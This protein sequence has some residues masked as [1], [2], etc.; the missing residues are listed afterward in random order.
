MPHCQ[1]S[2]CAQ[3]AMPTPCQPPR[4]S[5]SATSRNQA[6]VAAASRTAPVVIARASSGSGEP[7][8]CS[9]SLIELMFGG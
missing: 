5:N 2:Q 4:A 1:A 7:D 9:V 6:A 3:E 8:G